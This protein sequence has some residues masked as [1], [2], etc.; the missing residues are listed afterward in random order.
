MSFINAP[1]AIDLPRLENRSFP[2]IKRCDV[3]LWFNVP[4]NTILAM[5]KNSLRSFR[6][7]TRPEV[8]DIQVLLLAALSQ[9][10]QAA[11]QFR[12]SRW[13]GARN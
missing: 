7:F 2:E 4:I 9:R 8:N 12:E 13:A 10:H 1:T 5:S 6:T 3:E 11:Q